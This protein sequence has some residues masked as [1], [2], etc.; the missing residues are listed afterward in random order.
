MCEV[1]R[2]KSDVRNWSVMYGMAVEM[3]VR[4][5]NCELVVDIEGLR[6]LTNET[7]NIALRHDTSSVNALAG[8][9]Y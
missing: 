4:S 7:K 2:R 5:W 9:G 1:W 3:I 8:E 6:E